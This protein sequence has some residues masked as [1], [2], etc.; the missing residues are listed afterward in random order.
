MAQRR[1]IN[2]LFLLSSLFVVLCLA[3]IWPSGVQAQCGDVPADSSCITCHDQ[4]EPVYEKGEWHAIHA[5]KDCC[6]NCHGGNTKAQDKDLAHEGMTL[7]PVMD[8]YTNCYAC[9]PDDYT[10]RADRFGAALGV[11]PSSGEP[12]SQPQPPHL[13]GREEFELVLLP[14]PQ[15]VTLLATP[16]YP[17]VGLLALVCLA[18]VILF[19]VLER[20]QFQN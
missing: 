8:S 13:G 11:I 6:W 20:R 9:H 15:P 4:N 2:T 12:P 16:W 5:R 14:T 17:E 7:N 3:I 18:L 19:V 10:A 1:T